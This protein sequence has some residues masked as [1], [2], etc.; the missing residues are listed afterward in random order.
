M[1]EIKEREQEEERRQRAAEARAEAEFEAVVQT[2]VGSRLA[3]MG[4][5]RIDVSAA[6]RAA[7][8]VFGDAEAQIRAASTERSIATVEHDGR[9]YRLPPVSSQPFPSMLP[10]FG[11]HLV[12]APLPT[13]R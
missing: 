11:Y 7:I 12:R 10:R 5:Q 4:L 8:R 13:H 1:R 9:V 3:E 6:D 2:M